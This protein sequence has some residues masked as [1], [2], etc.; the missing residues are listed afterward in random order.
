MGYSDPPPPS[1]FSWGGSLLPSLY[2]DA[3]YI[4][5]VIVSK[6]ALKGAQIEGQDPTYL[7]SGAVPQKGPVSATLTLSLTPGTTITG[8]SFA[9]Q[10]ETGYKGTVGA[11]FK[12][13]VAGAAAYSTPTVNNYPYSKSGGIGAYSPPVNVAS[14]GLSIAVPSSGGGTRV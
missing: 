3:R 5:A 13:D 4:D 12:L 10:Y 11:N 8:V 9:Y 6:A 14:K 2:A 1:L 7:R